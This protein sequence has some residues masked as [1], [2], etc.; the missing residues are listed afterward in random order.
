MFYFGSSIRPYG[1]AM[2]L[3]IPCY[4]AFWR[5]AR[6]PTRWNV[7]ASLLLA[8]LS[9]HASYVNSCLLLGI[10]VAASTVCVLCR[11]WKRVLLILA[12]CFF[13]AISL[14][15]YVPVVRQYDEAAVTMKSKVDLPIIIDRFSATLS[16]NKVALDACRLEPPYL[17]RGRLPD[18]RDS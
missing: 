9:C 12:I 14:L 5:M 2:V 3:I 13:A 17:V 15:P 7:L 16:E 8:T 11:L 6:A 1:L 4:A 18:R 10:G